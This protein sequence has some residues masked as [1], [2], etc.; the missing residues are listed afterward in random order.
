[1]GLFRPRVEV[2][3]SMKAITLW[4]PWAS[5]LAIGRKKHETRSWKTKHRGWIAIHAAKRFDGLVMTACGR[6][7]EELKET[8]YRLGYVRP[9]LGAVVA[10]AKLERLIHCGSNRQILIPDF[11]E[12]LPYGDYSPGRWVWIFSEIIP[13]EPAIPATGGQR[14]WNWDAPGT[15]QLLIGKLDNL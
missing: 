12:A 11:Y 4:Q 1:M 3:E 14:V 10:V 2:C 8:G 7:S 6:F 13:V 5:L 9:P 15:I